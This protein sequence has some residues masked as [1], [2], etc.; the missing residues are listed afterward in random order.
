MIHQRWN[1]IYLAQ[2][3]GD[4]Y[5]ACSKTTRMWHALFDIARAKPNTQPAFFVTPVL[6]ELR[7]IR[8][9]ISHYPKLWVWSLLLNLL[10]H[11][12][13]WDRKIWTVIVT[14]DLALKASL[15]SS[16]VFSLRR[17]NHKVSQIR[18][19]SSLGCRHDGKDSG[20]RFFIHVTGCGFT[21]G[22]HTGSKFMEGKL[23]KYIYILPVLQQK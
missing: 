19:L 5:W 18:W 15:P 14:Y 17:T 22:I 13:T 6:V 11:L 7:L 16:F 20:R 8:L 23:N 2:F 21:A 1:P 12:N 4:F 10:H 3:R 9:I